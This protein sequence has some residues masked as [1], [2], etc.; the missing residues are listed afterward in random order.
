MGNQRKLVGY[1][2]AD[3]RQEKPWECV[4]INGLLLHEGLG[5]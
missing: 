3:G 5:H 1:T 2:R 4:I